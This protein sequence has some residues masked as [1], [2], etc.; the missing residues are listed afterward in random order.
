MI[1]FPKFRELPRII[2]GI[3]VINS[4]IFVVAFVISAFVPS[5]NFVIEPLYLEPDSPWQVWRLLTYFFFQKEPLHFVMNMLMLWMVGSSVAEW[6]GER[7]F[8]SLYLWSGLF[9]GLLSLFWYL[10]LHEANVQ[11]LGASGALYGVLVAFAWYFPERQLVLLIF[12]VPARVAV[13]IFVVIDAL[14]L[15]DSSVVARATHLSGVLGALLWLYTTE[16]LL[17]SNNALTRFWWRLR[18]RSKA[19]SSSKAKSIKLEV[20]Y[21]D[22]QKQLD[23]LLAKVS[24]NGIA[25]LAQNELEQLQHLSQK[26]QLR[27]GK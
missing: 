5:A 10:L 8:I 23:H 21:H 3:L 2:Q 12:P 14:L 22:E 6:I 20:G 25:A 27:K 7:K 19:Q 16:R 13:A 17:V 4:A 18:M 24:K 9:A 11:V 1:Y 15:A 26:I